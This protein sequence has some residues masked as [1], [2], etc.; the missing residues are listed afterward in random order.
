MKNGFYGLVFFAPSRRLEAPTSGF[1][2]NELR[3]LD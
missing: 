3:F 2:V 1:A